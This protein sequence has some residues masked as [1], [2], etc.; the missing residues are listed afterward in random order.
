MT[1]S[2]VYEYG[3][4]PKTS[5]IRN[6]YGLFCSNGYFLSKWSDQNGWIV[7][8]NFNRYTPIEQVNDLTKKI[9]CSGE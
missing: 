9:F 4:N 2:I 6:K 3:E 7:I 5:Y 8:T 1:Y